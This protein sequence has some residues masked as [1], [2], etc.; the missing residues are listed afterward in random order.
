M[1]VEIIVDEKSLE[2]NDFVMKATFNICT[3]LLDSLRDVGEWSKV[4][5]KI[6]K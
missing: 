1:K 4:E 5:I 2:L 6:E 3:G